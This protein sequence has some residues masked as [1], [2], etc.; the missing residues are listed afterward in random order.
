MAALDGNFIAGAWIKGP[1]A[2]CNLDT[3]NTGDIGGESAQGDSRRIETATA[4]ARAA[5]PR[6][7]TTAQERRDVLAGV[8][9]ESLARRGRVSRDPENGLYGGPNSHSRS[10]KQRR[11]LV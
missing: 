11:E 2:S 10:K 9:A 1:A 4:A 5:V 6:S 8:P 7:R 3:S